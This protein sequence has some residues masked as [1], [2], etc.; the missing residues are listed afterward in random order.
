VS[1]RS[2]PPERRR[3]GSAERLRVAAVQHDIRWEDRDATL[4]LLEGPVE[5]AAAMGARLVVLTE[6]FAVG[7][8]ADTEKVAEP[9]DG[10]TTQ[11]LGAHAAALD[12]WICGSVPVTTGGKPANRLVL[13]GP[14]GQRVTYD[15]IHPFTYAGEHTRFSS[16]AKAVSTAIDGVRTN[17]SVC[18]DLRFA[19]QYWGVAPTTDLYVVV[20]NWPATRRHHWRSLLV[21]RAIENQAYVVGVNRVGTG[22]PRPG[23]GESYV[24]DSCI[25][26]PLGEVLVQAA[27]VETIVSAD[28]DPEVV[29]ATRAKFPFLADRV[30]V[31]FSS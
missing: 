19:D 31:T 2:E 25:V 16:G 28:V 17:L 8:T 20:A 15:K 9:P 29:S 4:A 11:W 1:E 30:A 7:F 13:A 27:G 22:G 24:G 12:L 14:E 5:A 18:Y 6:M 23:D 3:A 10:P 26:D 21:A